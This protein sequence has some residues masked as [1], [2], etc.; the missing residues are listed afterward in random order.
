MFSALAFLPPDKVKKF[1]RLMINEANFHSDLK[2]WATN[3]FEPTWIEG[4][5]GTRATY[6]ISGWNCYTRF[7]FCCIF[8]SYA[9]Y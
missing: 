2:Y 1:Y 9:M 8:V 7:V 3:Y 4:P 5:N 6:Q